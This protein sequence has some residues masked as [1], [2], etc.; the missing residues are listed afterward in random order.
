MRALIID[1]DADVG[2][3]IQETLSRYAY[4]TVLAVRAYAGIHALEESKFDVAIVDIFM[5][6]MSGLD[7]INIIRQKTPGMP[8]VAMTG[9]RFRPSK[10]PE[11]DFLGLAVRRGAT[12]CVRK[13]FGPQQLLDAINS[14]FAKIEFMNGLSQCH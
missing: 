1:D 12:S 13:P 7:T 8:I 6:G 2:A 4:E 10:D 11:T 3:A 14:S 5:P 9:F